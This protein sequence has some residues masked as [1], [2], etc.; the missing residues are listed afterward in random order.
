MAIK[1]ILTDLNTD[2]NIGIGTDPSYYIDVDKTSVANDETRG[3]NIEL[4]KENTSGAGFASNVYGIKSHAIANSSQT[5]VNIGGVWNK[6]EHTGSG[7]IYFVTG[8]TNRAYHSGSGN[9]SSI[10]GVFSEA[11]IAGTGSG[12]HGYVIGVNSIAKLDNP[13]AT[14]DYLQGQHCTIQLVNG[15]A[16]DNV[17]NLLLD[18]DHTG[19]TISGDFEYLKIQNDT[20]DSAVGGTARAIN[21]ASV[22]PSE[23]GGSIQSPEF[24][25]SATAGYLKENSNGAVELFG[26]SGIY[27]ET[28]DGVVLDM[29]DVIDVTGQI[30]SDSSMTATSFVRSGGTSAQFLKA[31]GSVDTTVYTG[32]QDLSG[33]LLNT[34]DTLEGQ[35][36]VDNTNTVMLDLKRSGNLKAR[37]FADSNHA[38]L[39]MY[40]S[41]GSGTIR[42]LASGDSYLNGGNLGIGT[43][44]PG[45]A[46][47]IKLSDARIRIEDSDGTSQ[48]LEMRKNGAIASF[49]S[50]NDTSNGSYT[51][52]GYDGTTVSNFM[53][54]KDD[55][56]IG[57]GNADPQEKL[58][59]SAGDIRLDDNFSINW[60]SDDDNIGRVRI[61]G[62]EVPDTLVFA[63]DN[64]ERMRIA[65]VGVGI[66]TNDPKAKLDVDGA[67]RMGNDTTA[68][69][70]TN[71]GA[72][73]YYADALGSYVD[74]VMQTDTTTYAWVNIVRN[75]FSV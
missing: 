73:R 56:K 13:N 15:E 75:I 35:L 67:I 36:T 17:T 42:L 43:S 19:G 28:I 46:L 16:T 37:F 3:L 50:R 6:A 47:H 33:Y 62:N 64:S 34:T 11:K 48:F 60:A 57:I 40:N 21:S 53:T 22:L 9:S 20:F 69:S 32:N 29:S 2:G 49:R 27:I 71:V 26:D 4:S 38:Q 45:Q 58:D 14:V 52:D 63:T 51:F 66:G 65:N 70:A 44:N 10:S 59:I 23:F 7:Q 5:V 8:G 41:S 30:I 24:K 1:K 12:D 18:L 39:D 25:I 55:G 61:L 54:I 31:D 68:A 72:Q 74:M